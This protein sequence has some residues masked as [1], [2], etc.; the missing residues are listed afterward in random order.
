MQV[1]R[2][3]LKKAV[4]PSGAI[5]FNYNKSMHGAQ[6]NARFFVVYSYGHHFPIAVYDNDSKRW[7]L[8]RARYSVTTSRHQSLI[9]QN[10]GVYNEV[11]D[12]HE[13]RKIFNS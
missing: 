10:I 6:H 8:Q 7:T 12:Q 1:N 9:A 11:A 4:T 5:P 3:T 2:K 13:L